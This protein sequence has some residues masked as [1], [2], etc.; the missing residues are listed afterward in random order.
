MLRIF[1]GKDKNE[2]IEGKGLKTEFFQ[3]EQWQELL[4]RSDSE[5]VFIFKHS[6]RCGISSVILNKFEKQ[7]REKNRSYYFL[8]ILANRELSN[9]IADELNIRHESPQ[10]I[11]LKGAKVIA[12]DSHYRLLEISKSILN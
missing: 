8:N 3:K 4:D 7:M 10:L 9:W 12:Y 11:V 1:R 2:I 5:P 6:T